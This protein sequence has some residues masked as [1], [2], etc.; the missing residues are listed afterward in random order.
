MKKI[1]TNVTLSVKKCLTSHFINVTPTSG[2][3]HQ[4]S[5]AANWSIASYL[6]PEVANVDESTF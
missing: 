2:G 6:R 5:A 3:Q 1:L 4:H